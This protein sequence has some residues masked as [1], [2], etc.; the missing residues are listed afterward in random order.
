MNFSYELLE[1]L[2]QNTHK[3]STLSVEGTRGNISSS[4][5]HHVDQEIWTRNVITGK[6]R[7]LNLS[8]RK[9]RFNIANVNTRPGHRLVTVRTASGTLARL[10][11]ESMDT[12]YGADGRFNPRLAPSKSDVL[13]TAIG[14]TL[15]SLIPIIGPLG[16][17]LL[18][19]LGVIFGSC[20]SYCGYSFAASVSMLVALILGA[21]WTANVVTLEY[22]SFGEIEPSIALWLKTH[23]SWAF[24]SILGF[25]VAAFFQRRESFRNDQIINDGIHKTLQKAT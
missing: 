22:R 7:V 18:L 6:E 20:S 15:L 13:K 24:V 5:Q 11:S 25:G 19:L 12:S 4:T 21:L 17:A 10:Y 8:S 14:I 2:D 23:I 1:V 3:Y 16:L 9:G